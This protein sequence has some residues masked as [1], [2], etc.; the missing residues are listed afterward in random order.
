MNNKQ[1]KQELCDKLL[2]LFNLTNVEGYLSNVTELNYLKPGKT[3]HEV[4]EVVYQNGYRKEVNV[5]GDSGI[6]MIK[7][8]LNK[9]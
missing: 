5:W 7:D 6:S 8:V 3:G 9:L 1:Y 4:V 2:E